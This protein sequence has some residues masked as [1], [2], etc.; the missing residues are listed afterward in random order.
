[1]WLVTARKGKGKTTALLQVAANL[2]E[3]AGREG[4]CE[5]EYGVEDDDGQESSSGRVMFIGA[6]DKLENDAPD[7]VIEAW[8]QHESEGGGSGRKGVLSSIDV[9]YVSNEEE[10]KQT[11][12]CFHLIRRKPKALVVDDLDLI[13]SD[14]S[15]GTEYTPGIS[16]GKFEA[17]L[18]KI[19]AYLKNVAHLLQ[20]EECEAC[21][22]P[23][24]AAISKPDDPEMR[25]LPLPYLSTLKKWFSRIVEVTETSVENLGDEG[26][27]GLTTTGSMFCDE[28]KIIESSIV[29]SP[30]QPFVLSGGGRGEGPG[31]RRHRRE[32]VQLHR[33]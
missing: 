9:R 32:F 11:L 18:A 3:Q 14:A 33:P 17:R 6:K 30:F 16:F 28:C 19:S 31:A 7:H 27:A 2:A 20:R 21:P 25:L 10:L 24:I 26:P 15:T 8:E 1:M 4:E 12:A 29:T 22:G 5:E 13:L 23:V